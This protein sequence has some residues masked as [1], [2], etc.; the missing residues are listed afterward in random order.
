MR[1]HQRPFFRIL[2]AGITLCTVL[3]TASCFGASSE[4]DQPTAPD[5]PKEQTTPIN[6]VASVNQ[7][8]ALAEQIGGVHVKV[9]SILS[10][11]TEDAHTFEPKTTA[12]DTLQKAQVVVSNGAGYDSWATKNLERDTVSVSAAQMVGAVEGD[13]PHLW[14]SSDARNAMAKELADTYSRIMPKQKKYFT[15]KLKAWNRRETVIERSMKEFSD[16]HRNVSYAATEPVAYY[17]LSDMGL[18]DKTPES[19][20]QSIS[21]GS[22]P[23]SKELQDFQKI[24]EG[25]QVDMLINNVQKADDATNILTGTAHKSDVPVIDVTEQ[26]P[27]DSKSL[28]SWIAQLIKQMNEAVSSKDDATSSDSD[29]SP[30]ESNGEQRRTT[31]PTPIP[32]PQRRTTQGRRTP[33]NK[34]TVILPPPIRRCRVIPRHRRTLFSSNGYD[35]GG[36]ITRLF[37]VHACFLL[38]MIV[39]TV[40]EILSLTYQ[41][42]EPCTTRHHSVSNST[43]QGSHAADTS[44]GSMAPSVSRKAR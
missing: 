22:Q 28:I 31:I 1:S 13:N 37:I 26:M 18:S 8:G 35:P 12:V 14:F 33:V 34:A 9:T 16:T 42:S 23:S 15:N 10:S 27:A 21:E 3:G 4:P 6:V 24:L 38:R 5:T 44:S 25:H 19:Y 2:A 17:L 41:G 20:T 36:F 29:V 32:T 30:S 11:T 43:T 7:W 40:C 39:N